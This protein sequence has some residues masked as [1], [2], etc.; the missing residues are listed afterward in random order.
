MDAAEY[1]RM[2][3]LEGTHW[4]FTARRE[5]LDDAITRL[6]LP[7]NARILEAGCGTGGNLAMLSRHGQ[8]D[9][10]ETDS[11]A[12]AHARATHPDLDIRQGEL[13]DNFPYHD[14]RYDL[15]C[16]FDVLEHIGPDATALQTLKNHLNPGGRLLLTVP[17]LPLLWSRHD[18]AH[19]HH[20]RYTKK[21]LQAA[22]RA[23]GFTPVYISYFNTVLFP[24]VFG[25]RLA[26]KFRRVQETDLTLPPPTINRLLHMIFSSEQLVLKHTTLPIGVSLLAEA[27]MA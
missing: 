8:V 1:R 7:A 9:A 14:K 19:H 4:W 23:G 20:R 12:H 10:M 15:I 5:I 18:E 6:K 25:A 21:T 26:G 22:L 11:F 16:M 2:A 13:P 17:A 24:L 27:R 3:E